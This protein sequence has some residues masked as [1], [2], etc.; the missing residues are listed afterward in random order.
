[1]GFK[2]E[3]L[4]KIQLDA[5]RKIAECI[6]EESEE[7][8]NHTVSDEMLNI[9]NADGISFYVKR[10]DTLEFILMKNKKITRIHIIVFYTL[11]VSIFVRILKVKFLHC[12]VTLHDNLKKDACDSK[13]MQ[14]ARNMFATCFLH[15]ACFLQNDA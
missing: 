3:D 14:N 5:Y 4:Q 11:I 1:M 6:G 12:F 9:S 15:S 7:M 13:N 10:A 8:F 2:F